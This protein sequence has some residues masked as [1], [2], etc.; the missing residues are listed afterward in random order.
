M[1]F[2][3]FERGLFDMQKCLFSAWSPARPSLRVDWDILEGFI[4]YFSFFFRRN[5]YMFILC[6]RECGPNF[7]IGCIRY[8][9]PSREQSCVD[10]EQARPS[11]QVQLW[12]RSMVKEA[13]PWC[14]LWGLWLRCTP[15][16][17]FLPLLPLAREGTD[18][19][20]VPWRHERQYSLYAAEAK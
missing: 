20:L 11:V 9:S 8:L 5:Y 16:S 13:P 2:F 19:L 4:G 18:V 14:L 6:L 7:K 1:L 17:Q 15:E 10:K 3:Q 12:E